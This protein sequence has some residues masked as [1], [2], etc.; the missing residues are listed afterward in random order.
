MT[1]DATLAESPL[2][3][4]HSY[5]QCFDSWVAICCYRK[6]RRASVVEKCQISPVQTLGRRVGHRLWKHFTV[7]YTPIHGS[8]LNPAELEVS[9]WSRQCLGRLANRNVRRTAPP[10]RGLEPLVRNRRR[11]SPMLS[12]LCCVNDTNSSLAV[13]AASPSAG[14]L[15]LRNASSGSLIASAVTT[16]AAPITK[17]PAATHQSLRQ[18]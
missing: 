12:S 4:N 11:N 14:A 16:S 13:T 15:R 9:P 18:I 17:Q 5:H 1:T 7:Q 3:M 2:G 6:T 10:H 8:R